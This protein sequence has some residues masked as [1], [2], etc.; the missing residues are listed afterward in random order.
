MEPA[1]DVRQQLGQMTGG[2]LVKAAENLAAHEDWKEA[3]EFMDRAE[4]LG[5]VLN[6]DQYYLAAR[7]YRLNGEPAKAV[8]AYEKSLKKTL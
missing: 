1:Y 7:I 6:A 4:E 3:A 2:I 8:T 5:V